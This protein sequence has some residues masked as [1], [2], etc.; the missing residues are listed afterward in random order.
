MR[1]KRLGDNHTAVGRT[2]AQHRR[3][4]DGAKDYTGAVASLTEAESR[5]R[6]T[7]GPAHPEL[8]TVFYDPG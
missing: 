1:R 6:A 4:Q 7:L 8:V 3:R 2:L 5:L